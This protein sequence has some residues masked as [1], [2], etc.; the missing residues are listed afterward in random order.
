LLKEIREAVGGSRGESL[1]WR[2]ASLIQMERNGVYNQIYNDRTLPVL[3]IMRLAEKLDWRAIVTYDFAVT[4]GLAAWSAFCQHAS[5]IELAFARTR[6]T[7]LV[8]A[9]EHAASPA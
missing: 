4:G 6:L 9:S 7:Q 3:D 8:S 5:M 1:A 2:A